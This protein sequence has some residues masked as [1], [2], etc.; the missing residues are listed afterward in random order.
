MKHTMESSLTSDLR[1]V[2]PNGVSL[3][4]CPSPSRI[5][6][7][8]WLRQRPDLSDDSWQRFPEILRGKAL[9]QGDFVSIGP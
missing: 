7:G 8:R 9:A 5:H 4:N 2:P 1:P 6:G 3:L